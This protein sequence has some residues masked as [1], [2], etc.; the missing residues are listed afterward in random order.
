MIKW[1][2]NRSMKEVIH[3]NKSHRK[4]ATSALILTFTR[5][6]NLIKLR[7][8][9]NFN[10]WL[11]TMTFLLVMTMR[12]KEEIKE[13]KEVKVEDNIQELNSNIPV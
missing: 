8:N 4:T 9:N 11:I 5:K 7:M 1:N 6:K 2:N 13:N 10:K 3:I 12:M